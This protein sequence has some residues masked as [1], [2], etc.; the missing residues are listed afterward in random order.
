MI[1]NSFGPPTCSYATFSS[2]TRPV[3]DDID[4]Y[5]FFVG[6]NGSRIACSAQR[7]VL[8]QL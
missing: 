4:V 6:Q 5:C 8:F 3:G 1:Q 7:L 2:M